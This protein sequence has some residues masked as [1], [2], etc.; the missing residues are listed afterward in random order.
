M[1]PNKQFEGEILFEK[2]RVGLFI[3]NVYKYLNC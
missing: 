1:S 2:V 3:N